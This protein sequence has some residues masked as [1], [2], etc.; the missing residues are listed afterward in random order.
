VRDH[1]RP[2]FTVARRSGTQFRNTVI[3]V[4]LKRPGRWTDRGKEE[5][6]TQLTEYVTDHFGHTQHNIIF[7]LAG[8]GL[9]WK[10]Y[11]ARRPRGNQ[12]VQLT[13]VHDWQNDITTQASYM[14][15]AGIAQDVHNLGPT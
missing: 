2:D 12:L 5:V 9:R 3:V 10:L 4:E 11:R 6:K 14:M 8:I 7:A 1:G 13:V 15:F